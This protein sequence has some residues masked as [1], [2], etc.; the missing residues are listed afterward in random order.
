VCARLPYG[1]QRALHASAC[2]TS[3]NASPGRCHVVTDGQ[4]CVWTAGAAL[5]FCGSRSRR[6]RRR[7]TGSFVRSLARSLACTHVSCCKSFAVGTQH[8]Q[9][10]CTCCPARHADVGHVR[11]QHLHT[12]ATLVGSAGC[13]RGRRRRQPARAEL[14]KTSIVCCTL[15]RKAVQ[16]RL[17]CIHSAKR[18]K[19]Q[20]GESFAASHNLRSRQPARATQCSDR[21]RKKS[22]R[23]S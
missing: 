2:A 21:H 5:H 4:L 8:V 9:I 11:S 18:P 19:G 22:A 7:A 15:T 16:A 13:S 6:S 23:N 20:A 10:K 12:A 3:R 14:N 17:V 1:P